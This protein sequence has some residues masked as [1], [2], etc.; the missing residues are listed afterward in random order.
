VN[1]KSDTDIGMWVVLRRPIFL[2]FSTVALFIMA[3]LF[4]SLV[5][6]IV[7]LIAGW[8]EPELNQ[9]F[10]DSPF[11]QFIFVIVTDTLIVGGLY[12]LLK[13]TKFTF[14]QIGLSKPLLSDVWLALFAYITYLVVFVVITVIIK[15][16]LP[17]LDLEQQ[18][19]LVFDKANKDLLNIV[20]AGISLVILPPIVEELLCRGFLYTGLRKTLKIVPSAII[21]SIFFAMAHLQF[22]SDA[23]LLWVAAIDTFILS[24]MLIYLKEK[25]KRLVAPM[26]LHGFKNLL[27]FSLLFIFV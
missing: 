2:V 20:L 16:F 13:K 9:W 22:G 14:R 4:A 25:T 24:V 1:N 12:W 10:K 21:T 15:L 11:P 5:F 23:P 27:A 26:L 7:A 19:D 17:S 18:Q 3:Q 8:N 6:I